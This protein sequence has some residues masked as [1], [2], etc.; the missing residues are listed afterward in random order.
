MPVRFVRC[1]S[2]L[3][4]LLAAPAASTSVYIPLGGQTVVANLP[5]EVRVSLTNRGTAA[6]TAKILFL[7]AGT[8]GTQRSA[9]PQSQPVGPGQTLVLTRPAGTIGML[10]ISGPDD[11]LVSAHLATVAD[12]TERLPL[13]VVDGDAAFAPGETLHL[14]GLPQDPSRPVSLSLLNLGHAAAKCTATILGADGV[15]LAP[16]TTISLASLSQRHFAGVVPT[17]VEGEEVRLQVSCDQLFYAHALVG[18]PDSPRLSSIAPAHSARSSLDPDAPGPAG[19]PPG[20]TCF[21]QLGVVHTPTPANPVKRLVFPVPSGSYRR[22]LMRLDVKHG[23]WAPGEANGRHNL[24]WLVRGR[25]LNMIGS[26]D[27]YGPNANYLDLQHGM[28]VVHEDKVHLIQNLL[29]KPGATYHFDYVYDVGGRFLELVVTQASAQVARLRGVPNVSQLQI[30]A[31]DQ[32]L[33]DL[34]FDG[35]VAGEPP[36]Y[37]WIYSNLE[38]DFVP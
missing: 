13:P 30:A 14:Q 33:L 16:S 22:V 10:E 4:L 36:T 8:D 11:L 32:I 31:S 20:G 28:G 35:S 25:N 18:R 34:G 15:A 17:L 23:G 29:A 1:W 21:D 6:A 24:F 3:L 5:V 19:C 9:P 27:F 38:I 12:P 7:A 2:V 26:A 37:N